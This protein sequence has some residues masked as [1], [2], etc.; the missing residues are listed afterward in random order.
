MIGPS[1]IGMRRT[2]ECIET[3]MV[4]LCFGSTAATRLIVAG[5]EMAVHERKR[6]APTITACQVGNEDDDRE[7]RPWR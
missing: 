1:A 2:S 7:S 5:S 4:R 3:P 6:T